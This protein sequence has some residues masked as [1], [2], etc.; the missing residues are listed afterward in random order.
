MSHIRNNNFGGFYPPCPVRHCPI[1]IRPTLPDSAGA[2]Y[3]QRGTEQTILNGSPV[4]LDD[5]TFARNLG[6][7]I[8]YNTNTGTITVDKSGTYLFIWSLL[9]IS[10]GADENIIIALEN[11]TTPTQYA[12]SGNTGTADDTNVPVVGSTVVNLTAGTTLALI[13]RSGYGIELVP[14]EAG[15]LSFAGSLTAVRLADIADF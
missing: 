13:N 12:L 7:G 2:I 3:N 9:A 8:S 6:L 4:I 10:P 14:A 1:T 15:T 11:T 5:T